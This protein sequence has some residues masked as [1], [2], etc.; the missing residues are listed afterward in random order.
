MIFIIAIFVLLLIL[1]MH[2]CGLWFGQDMFNLP[3]ETSYYNDFE[4]RCTRTLP[5]KGILLV[6]K[7]SPDCVLAAVNESLEAIPVLFTSSLGGSYT[8]VYNDLASRGFSV[9]YEALKGN[10]TDAAMGWF[11]LFDPYLMDSTFNRLNTNLPSNETVQ[12]L[13]VKVVHQLSD[14]LW[15]IQESQKFCRENSIWNMISFVTPYIK[16]YS[17][18]NLRSSKGDGC[19]S[20]L[21]YHW[22]SW[23]RILHDL[24]DL[25]YLAE[26][27]NLYTLCTS[28]FL[29][30]PDL[31]KKCENKP[32]NSDH[33]LDKKK[34]PKREIT[35]ED[36]YKIDCEL[37]NRIFY[38]AIEY[39]YEKYENVIRKCGMA[40]GIV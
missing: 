32:V 27:L 36:L 6:N 21:M 37:A 5:E 7:Y 19:I 12:Y 28:S 33:L 8:K 34:E 4:T 23:N 25:T 9:A 20:L 39:G 1:I 2:G 24:S 17:S 16:F 26:N 13:F 15:S 11:H 18:R 31:F 10:G 35:A 14:P 3:E 29:N 38:S 22:W 30:Y 40:E